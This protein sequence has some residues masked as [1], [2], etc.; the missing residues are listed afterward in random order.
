MK[1]IAV[2]SQKGGCGKTTLV[3]H[4]AV[5]A[6]RAGAGPVMMIDGDPQGTLTQWW[7]DRGS[8]TPGL[9]KRA[10]Q[11]GR[12]H[13]IG[14][15]A[16]IQSLRDFGARFVFIDT[17]PGITTEIRQAIQYADIAV[18][19]VRPSPHDLRA[20]A[21]TVALAKKLGK[22]VLF[23][24]N[25]AAVRSRIAAD[26]VVAL[27]QHGPVAPVIV[28]QRV[29]FAVSMID[30]GTTMERRPASR[31]SQEMESL[32]RYLDDRIEGRV[33]LALREVG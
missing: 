2:A 3:A 19:P 6:E 9:L 25:G 30:G 24:I 14:L 21:A 31:S 23:V 22:E 11:D 17:P 32:W 13:D 28:H 18:I 20:S 1:L 8:M 33:D 16:D 12:I 26:A 5:Q 7:T 10:G 27:A 4:L 29:D 15:P